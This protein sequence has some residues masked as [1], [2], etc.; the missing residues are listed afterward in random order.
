MTTFGE[1]TVCGG[2][3]DTGTRDQPA[4]TN[5]VCDEWARDEQD[6]AEARAEATYREQDRGEL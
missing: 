5:C 4:Y 2:D 6:E 1:C 3:W